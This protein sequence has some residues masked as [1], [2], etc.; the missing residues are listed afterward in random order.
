[1]L[2]T[3]NRSSSWLPSVTAWKICASVKDRGRRREEQIA[4]RRRSSAE[5][6][7]LHAAIEVG[8]PARSGAWT[9]LAGRD[10][11][12]RETAVAAVRAVA[13]VEELEFRAPA[14]D[15]S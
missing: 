5:G 3:K 13:I 7:P 4:G 14:I 15:L 11:V 6:V 1:M 9:G 8:D 12:R 2:K 10:L